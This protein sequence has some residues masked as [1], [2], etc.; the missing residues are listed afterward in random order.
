MSGAGEL[1]FDGPRQA[2][3]CLVLAHGASSA[4]DSPG[5]A[6]LA[7]GIAAAGVQVARFEFPYM[8]RRRQTGKGGAPDRPAVLEETW[9]AAVGDVRAR[10]GGGQ[11]LAVGGRSMGGRVATM[12]ADRIGAAAAVCYGYPFH[13]PGRPEKVRTA[14]LADLATATLI[15]QGE[16]DSFG[17]PDDVAGYRLAPTIRVHWIADG[18]HTLKPRKSSGRTLE[19]NTAEA[20]GETVRFLAER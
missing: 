13:P 12:V 4:M 14:H 9:L 8:R 2:S 7:E 18:D 10:L 6:A 1:L 16:R 15:L 20:V 19:E 17:T 3:I 5:M 11:R